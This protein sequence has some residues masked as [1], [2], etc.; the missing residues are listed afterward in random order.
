MAG[1][2]GAGHGTELLLAQRGLLQDQGTPV[3]EQYMY[4]LSQLQLVINLA[5]L[6]LQYYMQEEFPAPVIIGE[7]LTYR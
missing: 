1:R 3:A 2:S 7:Y 5:S 6:T 4:L